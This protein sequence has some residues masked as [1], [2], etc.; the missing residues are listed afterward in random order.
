[1]RPVPGQ[2]LNNGGGR[3]GLLEELVVVLLQ[4]CWSS[5]SVL[6]S[7][8]PD[9]GFGSANMTKTQRC[10]AQSILAYWESF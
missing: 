2:W 9:F 8:K 3:K 5:A 10:A 1:M 6:L 4:F 7:L